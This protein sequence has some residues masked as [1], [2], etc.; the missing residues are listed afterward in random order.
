MTK[1]ARCVGGILLCVGTVTPAM[2]AR[3]ESAPYEI[4]DSASTSP[5]GRAQQSA[6]LASYTPVSDALATGSVGLSPGIELPSGRADPLIDPFPR[7]QATKAKSE[8]GTG[9]SS[10]EL[11]L[12]RVGERGFVRGDKTD[13]IESPWGSL[14]HGSDGAWYPIGLTTLVRVQLWKSSDSPVDF[15]ATARLSNGREFTYQSDDPSQ[16]TGVITRW[17]LISALADAPESLTTLAWEPVAADGRYYLE[18]VEWGLRGGPV[19]WRAANTVVF[20]HE[21]LSAPASMWR[22]GRKVRL[23][24]RVASASIAARNLKN[25]TWSTIREYVFEHEQLRGWLFLTGI[26]DVRGSSQLRTSYQYRRP[27]FDRAPPEAFA[28]APDLFLTTLPPW[29]NPLTPATS[30]PDVPLTL[31]T[32]DHAT[33]NSSAFTVADIDGDGRTDLE[34]NTGYGAYRQKASGAPAH[35]ILGPTGDPTKR[36]AACFPMQETNGPNRLLTR[37][38]PY[39]GDPSERSPVVFAITPTVAKTGQT[40]ILTALALDVC[41]RD[42][43]LIKSTN[44]IATTLERALRWDVFG[45]W[46][47]ADLDADSKPD[48]VAFPTADAPPAWVPNRSKDEGGQNQDYRFGVSSG[49]LAQTF[50]PTLSPLYR[51]ELVDV[52]GDGFVDIVEFRDGGEGGG[53]VQ[54]LAVA[55][56]AGRLDG[57][58]APVFESFWEFYRPSSGL[59]G[60]Y[61]WDGQ[62]SRLVRGKYDAPC[63]FSWVDVDGDLLADLLMTCNQKKWA[64]VLLNTGET[65]PLPGQQ[66]SVLKAEVKLGDNFTNAFM[67]EA[68]KLAF[69]RP[70]VSAVAGKPCPQWTEPLPDG[71]GLCGSQV[72]LLSFDNA[73]NGLLEKVVD[74]FG[75][76]LEFLYR[77]LSMGESPA[78]GRSVEV[79]SVTV[80]ASGAPT[81]IY[82]MLYEAPVLAKA[83]GL[84]SYFQRVHV[85]LEELC[86]TNENWTSADCSSSTSRH[87]Y[88]TRAYQ[89]APQDDRVPV[90]LVRETVSEGYPL[91]SDLQQPPGSAFAIEDTTKYE[92]VKFRDVTLARRKETVRAYLGEASLNAFAQHTTYSYRADHP[93]CLAATKRTTRDTSTTTTFAS[94]AAEKLGHLSCLSTRTS[95]LSQSA[96]T[97]T[98]NLAIAEAYRYE[99]TSGIVT[100]IRRDK[101]PQDLIS[102]QKLDV[103]GRLSSNWTADR[104]EQTFAYEDD[105]LLVSRQLD[106]D[107]RTLTYHWSPTLPLVERLTTSRLGTS[108]DDY[109]HHDER[110]RR[111]A[112]WSS[113]SGSLQSPITT[114]SYHDA[115]AT[116]PSVV[117]EATR[118]DASGQSV[119]RTATLADGNGREF[120][121][122]RFV[123]GTWA[124]SRLIREAPVR[125]VKTIVRRAPLAGTSTSILG[126]TYRDLFTAK[127]DVVSQERRKSFGREL[128]LT[129][130][131]SATQKR[132]TVESVRLLLNGFEIRRLVNNAQD[133]VV[134]TDLEWRPLQI[135]TAEGRNQFFVRD[136]LGRVRTFSPQIPEG[137]STYM[138]DDLGR[139]TNITRN[140]GSIMTTFAYDGARTSPRQTRT[141]GG[142]I[143][144]E[145][146]ASYT[147]WGAPELVTGV[148]HTGRLDEVRY[149]YAATTQG[150]PPL[151]GLP[152]SIAISSRASSTAATVLDTMISQ[153][154]ATT[155]AL[156]IEGRAFFENGGEWRR[157]QQDVAYFLDGSPASTTIALNRQFPQREVSIRST[158]RELKPDADALLR[159]ETIIVTKTPGPAGPV[160]SKS[161]DIDYVL[162]ARTSII[163]ARWDGRAIDLT[164]DSATSLITD[165]TATLTAGSPST[166]FHRIWNARGEVEL[167]RLNGVDRHYAYTNDGLL[168]GAT[169]TAGASE[170]Y[171]YAPSGLL[172][173]RTVGG[174]NETVT[175]T[176]S[177]LVVGTH[178]AVL[179]KLARVTTIDGVSLTYSAFDRVASTSNGARLLYGERGERSLARTGTNRWLTV[180]DI[181]SDGDS[182]EMLFR[183]GPIVVGT[184][185]ADG[186]TPLVADE[187]G[188]RVWEGGSAQPTSYG[189]RNG[190][191]SKVIDFGGGGVE[192]TTGTISLG[193][194]DYSPALGQFLTADPLLVLNPDECLQ[195]AAT[196]HPNTYAR[197]NPIGFSDPTGLSE[198]NMCTND[199]VCREVKDDVPVERGKP[200]VLTPEERDARARNDESAA[201]RGPRGAVGVGFSANAT[202][203]IGVSLSV[204][205]V[206]DAS[207][208]R[209]VLVTPGLRF[210]WN[211]GLG[212]APA[213]FYSPFAKRDDLLG[214]SLGL[215][216]DALAVSANV[217]SSVSHTP[218]SL[219]LYPQ[220]GASGP[221]WKGNVG[222]A[223]EVGYTFLWSEPLSDRWKR[224]ELINTPPRY[225][226]VRGD[227]AAQ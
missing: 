67:F 56:H 188:T 19:A 122:A 92:Y 100:T 80:Q 211:L 63:R 111:T 23:S 71:S 81:K 195:K 154:Y 102:V 69:V 4:A 175:R 186:F 185:G 1:W 77:P 219:A 76:Q 162:D 95:A 3:F 58:G 24:R 35:E 31:N 134:A 124:L 149:S 226:F 88:M 161:F 48:L 61:D 225:R 8:W 135:T 217:S 86:R 168:A 167:E 52:N 181:R 59:D 42:G 107:G 66:P 224:E 51:H 112:H 85:D 12:E 38:R 33:A 131:V 101:A 201:S 90:L 148:D 54:S 227:K 110:F 155:G 172:E 73:A 94:Y 192:P 47:L 6:S 22:S 75:G 29:N 108:R 136:A 173:K 193:V 171:W 202:A 178:Q 53:N 83:T 34:M 163:G 44:A 79:A 103:F 26:V 179:D 198:Q 114:W 159:K 145:V 93:Y 60:N 20:R 15:Y 207:G 191:A 37:L 166:T 89:R 160:T 138:F 16:S 197:A 28:V 55:F 91:I 62:V 213:A 36:R 218:D 180:G 151:Q 205:N 57:R 209:G 49:A 30:N 182:F 158:T 84:L 68:S 96:T 220:V 222:L 14:R 139:L 115:D 137:P 132:S 157:L 18:S 133:T 183:V 146:S 126:V 127:L 152:T 87:T 10:S 11:W 142:G 65:E 39:L 82:R 41:S 104:G 199:P 206:L 221:G 27:P 46:R 147:T 184:L 156:S 5:E 106:P 170:Q 105:T 13:V 118:L 169:T 21:P 116:H 214:L 123:G 204:F 143:F 120:G 25:G 164:R 32:W 176:S 113:D 177:K 70:N 99:Y 7:Y 121:T 50:G 150:R 130:A 45:G 210:G 128:E 194:R 196:C 153:A 190:T 74:P 109:W 2:G 144:T 117:L 208:S 165:W 187:R 97:T 215:T 141:T 43:R 9:W 125:Q 200:R 212:V 98:S 64:S 119:K 203:L 189:Q 129:E 17:H 216:L 72:E 174:T 140:G 78:L 40:E 223:F